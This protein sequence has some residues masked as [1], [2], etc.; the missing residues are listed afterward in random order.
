MD[1]I[2][3]E[4]ILAAYARRARRFEEIASR[5]HDSAGLFPRAAS[6]PGF[7]ASGSSGEEHPGSLSKRQQ[8]V[9]SLVARG[10]SNAA[11]GEKL[12]ISVETV[13]THV[14][15]ILRAL[16]AR[17]RAHAVFL[18]CELRLLSRAPGEPWWNC[19]D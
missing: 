14:E 5:H 15:H 17:N 16:H 1:A 10:S 2:R 4:Q 11:I 8:Q 9:L 7:S 19:V 12:G 3:R 6:G 13:K 18:G